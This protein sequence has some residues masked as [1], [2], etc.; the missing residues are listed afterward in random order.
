MCRDWYRSKAMRERPALAYRAAGERSPPDGWRGVACKAPRACCLTTRLSRV[1]S[2]Q[3]C[4]D[5]WDREFLL[6]TLDYG[7]AKSWQTH[8]VCLRAQ[9]WP[10]PDCDR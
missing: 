2:A 9:R 6:N 1:L 3:M 4:Q 7:A 5:R 8:D 10:D